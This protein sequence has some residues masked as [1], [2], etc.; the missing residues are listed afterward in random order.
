[1]HPMG[2]LWREYDCPFFFLFSTVNYMLVV[3]VVFLRFDL[4]IYIYWLTDWWSLLV[5]YDAILLSRA[6]SLRRLTVILNE[7]LWLFMARYEYPRAALFGCY[8]ADDS[9]RHVQLLPSRLVLCTPYNHAACHV[10]SCKLSH[11]HRVPRHASLAVTCHLRFWQNDR[12]L[13]CAG[14]VLR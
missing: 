8:R 4:K 7:W 12:D 1:M 3:V 5:L 13:L 2:C 9:W 6:D 14:R 10:T 11:I